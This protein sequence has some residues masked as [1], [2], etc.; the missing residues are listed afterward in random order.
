M[1]PTVFRKII[2]HTYKPLLEYYLSGERDYTYRGIHIKVL[3]GVFHPGFFFSTKIL[4]QFLEPFNLESKTFLELGAGTGL[5]SVWAANKGANVTAS[6][7]SKKAVSNIARNEGINHCVIQKFNSDLFDSI[8]LQTFDFIVINPPYYKKRALSESDYAWAAGENLEYFEK[9]FS[10]IK[11]FMA[12][13]TQVFMILINDC[14]LEAIE[15][16][17][18][19]NQL[20]IKNVFSKE[21]YLETAVVYQLVSVNATNV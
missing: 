12:D 2:H 13:A 1:I 21:S 14:E 9:L 3:P 7:I 8:P 19:K 10:Q 5:I 17:A 6:D 4:L 15:S 18:L 16:M 11:S 20:K